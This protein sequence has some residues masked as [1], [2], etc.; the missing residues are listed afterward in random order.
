MRETRDSEGFQ[1]S[2][3]VEISSESDV[4]SEVGLGEAMI[5]L[6]MRAT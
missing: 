4:V 6:A 1:E 5:K 3:N 2:L